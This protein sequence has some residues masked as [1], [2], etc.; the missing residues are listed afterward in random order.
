MR[1]LVHVTTVDK[2]K[3]VVCCFLATSAVIISEK[4][5]KKRK[6][7]SEKWYLKRDISRD[8]LLLNELLEAD[9]P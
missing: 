3:D 8:A 7:W 6:M 4:K 1:L 9:V 2:N 5:K